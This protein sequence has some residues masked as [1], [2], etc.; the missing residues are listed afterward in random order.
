[1]YINELEININIQMFK[2]K[3]INDELIYYLTIN[4]LNVVSLFFMVD[5]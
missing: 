4:P 5:L 1:M 2:T 3:E